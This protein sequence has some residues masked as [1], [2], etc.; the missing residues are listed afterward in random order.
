MSVAPSC[1]GQRAHLRGERDHSTGGFSCNKLSEENPD[2][3]LLLLNYLDGF[4]TRLDS[5]YGCV[6][7]A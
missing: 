3:T 2:A 7:L 1:S 4:F 5:Y 6:S